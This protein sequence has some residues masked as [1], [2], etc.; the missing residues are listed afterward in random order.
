MIGKDS[1][2]EGYRRKDDTARGL[3]NPSA[4]LAKVKRQKEEKEKKE[5]RK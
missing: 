5:R 1:K 4:H 2:E 3:D